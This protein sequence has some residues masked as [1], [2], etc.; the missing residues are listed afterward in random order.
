MTARKP[1]ARYFRGSVEGRLRFH[2][3]PEPNS[4]CILWIGA[5]STKSGHGYAW[6]GTR[7][8]PAHI[9]SYEL[10]KGPVHPDKELHH[11]CK[12]PCCINPDHLKPVTRGEHQRLEPRR[13]VGD[14]THCK[15]GHELTFE[16]S[17]VT[18]KGRRSCR[19][20]HR[21]RARA[22]RLGLDY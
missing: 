1:G 21:E 9:V 11:L 19:Q 2:S 14:V 15:R 6:D 10:S 7:V 13:W 4:G 22:Y 3:I 17:Y 5:C 16:N 12:N 20:C 8:R 18:S